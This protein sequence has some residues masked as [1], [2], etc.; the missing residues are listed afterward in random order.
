VVAAVL[1]ISGCGADDSE[2]TA[3]GTETTST[4]VMPTETQEKPRTDTVVET[5]TSPARTETSPSAMPGG[6]EPD[7]GDEEP[8][9]TLALFTGRGGR[10]TPRLVRVPAF[11][12]IEVQLRS[13]DGADYG[14]R[15]GHTTIRSGGS[16]TF[17]GLRPNEAIVG[18]PA[19]A[20][21]RVRISA[22]AEPGP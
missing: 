20:G 1:A 13:G 7:S 18:V 11:I 9:R 16:A 3:V 17:D 21:N 10:I 8:A 2:T 12:A 4:E 5:E 15:F 14:L 6:G 19:G 22:T